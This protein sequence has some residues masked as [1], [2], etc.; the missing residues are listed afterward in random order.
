MAEPLRILLL[1][2]SSIGLLEQNLKEQ[3]VQG[4]YS[5]AVDRESF[6]RGLER[7]PDLILLDFELP[8]FSATE[9]LNLIR[10][11]GNHIPYIVISESYGDDVRAELAGNE[12]HNFLLKDQ[13]WLLENLVSKILEKTKPWYKKEE[14]HDVQAEGELN[15]SETR[16]R[17]LIENSSDEFAILSPDGTLLY[18]S[19]SAK[20][21]L[22]YRPRR[23]I[24]RNLFQLVHPDDLK[25][26]LGKYKELAR[27][28][29]FQSREEFRLKHRDGR[30]VWVEA[31]ATNLIAEPSVG[32]IVVNFHDVTDRKNAEVALESAEKDYRSIFENAPIGIFQSTPDGRFIKV[33]SAMAAMYGYDSPDDMLT[34][35]RNIARQI[36]LK[37][38]DRILFQKELAE[39]GNVIGF[40]AQNLR[41]DGSSFWIST[42]ARVEMD[43]ENNILYYEGFIYDITSRK[44]AEDA[45][46]QQNQHLDALQVATQAVMQ[47]LH[48]DKIIEI[49]LGQA[50][51]LSGCENGYVYQLTSDGSQIKVTHVVGDAFRPNLGYTLESGEGLAG[52]VWQSGKPLAVKNYSDWEGH[53]TK[54]D[55]AEIFAVIGVP[56]FSASHVV[57]VL[58]LGH[59]EADKKFSEGQ[60]EILNRFAQ[61]ASIALEHARLYDI[62]QK[63]L[64]ERKQVE[65][66]LRESEKTMRL[67]I[68]TALDAVITMDSNGCITNWNEQAE[69]IFGW[70]HEE[71]M[72]RNLAELIIPDGQQAAHKKGMERYK[73]MGPGPILNQRVEMT[74]K[75]RDG[76]PFPLELTVHNLTINGRDIFASFIR[77]I[78]E[79]KHYEETLLQFRSMMDQSNDAILM[80][81]PETG[82]YID[83]NQRACVML[84]YERNELLKSD[85]MHIS[86]EISN[87]GIWQKKVRVQKEHRG[88]MV[89]T[90]YKRKDGS[91]FPVEV[92]INVIEYNGREII[93]NIVRDI[94]EREQAEAERKYLFEVIERSLNEIYIFDAVELNFIYANRGALDNLKYEL[95]ELKQMTP[96]DIKPE[97]TDAAFRKL[98]QKLVNGS[99]DVL[100]FETSHLR[101]DGSIYPVEVRLQLVAFE[102]A[103]VF[104]AVIYDITER[105]AA[106]AKYQN[107][108]ERLPLVV[109]SSE[110]G[111]DGKWFYVSPQIEE[112]L[113]Y[114]PDEWISE[115]NLWYQ[116]MHIDDRDIEEQLEEDAYAS[117]SSYNNEYR[118]FR[119]DGRQIWVRDSGQIFA[120]PDGGKPIIQGILIDV[121]ERKK[122]EDEIKRYARNT[123]VLYEISEQIRSSVDLD[124]VYRE[125]HHAIQQVMPCEALA[126]GLLDESSQEIE[127]VYLWDKGVRW[128]GERY[129]RGR[130]LTG[131][132]INSGKVLMINEWTG[133]HD[134]IIDTIS[135][136]S[137]EDTKSVLAAPLFRSDGQC[138]GMVSPQSYETNAFTEEHERLLVTL[139]N[140]LSKAI[141]N[142]Q[143]FT[144]LQKSNDELSEAYDA[145]IEGWSRAMDL[146]DEETEGHTQRV[147]RL[148]LRLAKAMGFSS[149]ELIHV[150]RGALL[151]DIGK[152]GV[153]DSILFKKE[154]LTEEEWDIMRQHPAF[155]YEMLSHVPYL[156]SALDIPYCHHEKWDGSGYPQGLKSSEIP[157][158]ARIFAVADVW[159]A[160][161]SDRPYRKAWT[162]KKALQ[163]IES[164][165][166]IHFD[167]KVVKKFI[168]I[169]SHK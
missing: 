145:T 9:A 55:Q 95:D 4:R 128:L 43:A 39:N 157:L 74:G 134:K 158:S 30:W 60:I 153:P 155:A 86:N 138:F 84:G 51:Q 37:S 69:K 160:V 1:E 105:K 165:S 61:L 101:S 8:T 151:H 26:V 29:G 104:L 156:R 99:Q 31:V 63:E 93:L 38:E 115:P 98:I 42:N 15:R 58:G 102:N 162:K 81:D 146:R 87:I 2:D 53:S 148:T 10:E 22:G 163:Y 142:A 112:L 167:P 103:R 41:K 125:F 64:V 96:V 59:F 33:N 154:K 88:M 127:D 28:P 120:A 111:V 54:F 17:S 143:L 18:E 79:R 100:I 94:T 32:G 5:R 44:Q 144:E 12:E 14:K 16:F 7:I 168:S 149:D 47:E 92:S 108:V 78:T 57:G 161:T 76:S 80:V 159:D 45:L 71:A 140:Q 68:D 106:E 46:Q 169:M 77:D 123:T 129:P 13:L 66:S 73:K 82:N 27:K 89:E 119:K 116:R 152:L 11:H 91:L 19:P 113:G 20:P 141:E 107:L 114:T 85:I 126:I 83:C 23:F 3:G 36:Y 164:E 118:I 70:T 131:W 34:N 147:T 6:M 110:L 135:F 139:A 40:E 124:Q 121:T 109:Y 24:G 122:T 166:E 137:S 72:G 50:A 132:V 97:F 150:R 117:G 56:L 48:I 62:S 21:T 65:E 75:R 25:Y 136:G 52:K 67:I 133:E 130:N 49:I 35:I 90:I